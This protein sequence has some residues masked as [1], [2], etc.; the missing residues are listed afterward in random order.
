MVSEG[1]VLAYKG[2]IGRVAFDNDEGIFHGEVINM[3][4]VVTFQ[5]SSVEELRQAFVDSVDDYLD[6]CKELGQKPEKPYYYVGG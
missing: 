1:G 4:D 5:G 6:F 2:Y 3:R